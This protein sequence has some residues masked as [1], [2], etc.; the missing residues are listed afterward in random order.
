LKASSEICLKEILMPATSKIVA[1]ISSGVI[2]PMA[3][4]KRFQYVSDGLDRM[5]V[6]HFPVSLAASING[7]LVVGAKGQEITYPSGV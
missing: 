2:Q 5:A 3:P 1:T 7:T 4:G 6:T